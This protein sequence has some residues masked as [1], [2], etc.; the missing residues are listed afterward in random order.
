MF[1]RKEGA[2]SLYWLGVRD[3][4]GAY[5]DGGDAYR[6]TVPLPVPAKL[7]WS[8]TVYDNQTRIRTHTSRAHY[9]CRFALIAQR[10]PAAFLKLA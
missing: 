8:I 7:F 9:C 10:A 4:T 1:A 2:G 6:L 3:S 5:L